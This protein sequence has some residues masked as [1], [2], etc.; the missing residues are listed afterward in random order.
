MEA[1]PQ[2]AFVPASITMINLDLGPYLSRLPEE[3]LIYIFNIIATT[4]FPP[5]SRLLSAHG[6]NPDTYAILNR[7]YAFKR[8]RTVSK[9]FCALFMQAFYENLHFVCHKPRKPSPESP[10]TYRVPLMPPTSMRRFLR[11]LRIEFVLNRFYEANFKPYPD[12]PG[13]AGE[14]MRL[15]HRIDRVKQ[16]MAACP[17]MRALSRLTHPVSGFC[18]LAHLDLAVR[19]DLTSYTKSRHA[20][21]LDDAFLTALKET[22]IV[23]KAKKVTLTVTDYIPHEDCQEL[24]QPLP[25]VQEKITVIETG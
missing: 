15:R 2:L 18:N 11:T 20:L 7:H 3:L 1:N 6:F 12:V 25:K 21:T 13:K 14:M 10:E 16:L 22:K 23:V 19:I 5:T 8:I 24:I 4:L 17:A 9:T